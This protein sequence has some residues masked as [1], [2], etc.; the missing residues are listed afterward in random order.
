MAALTQQ[1]AI[2][3]RPAEILNEYLDELDKHIADLKNGTAEMTYE[4]KDIAAIMH[5]HPRHLSNTIKETTG[6]SP[7]D[8]YE[9]KL[10]AISKDLIL[11]SD[12]SIA[13]IARHLMY[14]PS[15]FN[16]FFK[17]YVGVTPKAFRDANL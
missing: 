12:K 9:Q 13:A 7:C 15:N 17:H 6:K 2:T 10:I 3:G 5:I 4:I 14:D 11:T 8:F 16:K 1:K